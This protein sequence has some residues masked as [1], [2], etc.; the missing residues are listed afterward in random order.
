MGCSPQRSI[1]YNR[2]FDSNEIPGVS[3]PYVRDSK[4]AY[5]ETEKLYQ[6]KSFIEMAKES[7]EKHKDNDFLG[8]RKKLDDGNLDNKFTF[9]K[10]GQVWQ[11]S[12]VLAKNIKALGLSSKD[13]TGQYEFVGIY[14]RN[15]VEWTVLKT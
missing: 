7:A 11:W 3:G 15:C 14:S 1:K 6:N 13:E 4:E 12:E 8:Y 2:R 9:F 5:E 10:Y